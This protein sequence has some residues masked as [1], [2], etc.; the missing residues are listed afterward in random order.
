M[1]WDIQRRESIIQIKSEPNCIKAD[2]PS[3][4]QAALRSVINTQLINCCL[5]FINILGVLIL[6]MLM[7]AK[8][9]RL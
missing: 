8:V 7:T 9:S 4:A 2:D 5:A 1:T 6:S 3:G